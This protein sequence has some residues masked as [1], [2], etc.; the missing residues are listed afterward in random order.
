V[1]IVYVRL[2]AG[3]LHA[4]FYKLL[5]G[6]LIGIIGGPYPGGLAVVGA[7]DNVRVNPEDMLHADALARGGEPV[8]LLRG[9]AGEH[10]PFL[11]GRA[12]ILLIFA[13]IISPE[14]KDGERYCN[15]RQYFLIGVCFYI[16]IKLA[17]Q[18]KLM[19]HHR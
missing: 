1:E 4:L 11:E 17:T 5:P 18:S 2:H 15:N 14:K 19:W 13:H 7:G 10:M 3:C 9:G 16:L 8:A 12:D 6:H